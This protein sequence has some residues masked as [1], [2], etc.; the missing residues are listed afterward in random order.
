MEGGRAVK[1]SHMGR[2][3]SPAQGPGGMMRL[4]ITWAV[5][6]VVLMQV[7]SACTYGSTGDGG[8]GGQVAGGRPTVVPTSPPVEVTGSEGSDVITARDFD[9]ANFDEPT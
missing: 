7:V 8:G 2:V 1:T 5:L 9:A 3:R 6:A 4:P